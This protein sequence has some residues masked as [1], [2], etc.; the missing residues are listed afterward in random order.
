MSDQRDSDERGAL[1]APPPEG[2]RVGDAVRTAV[3]RTLAATA[4]S[5]EGTRQ[6]AQDLLDDVVRRG[7]GAREEVARR[8]DEATTKLAE[9]LSELR[10]EDAAGVAELVA[11]LE[12]VERRLAALEAASYPSLNRQVEVEDSAQNPRQ[13]RDSGD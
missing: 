11:R 2:E 9:A 12:T 13:Q 5:A 10:R 3:E 1:D 7:Q 6:R 4:D 8:R